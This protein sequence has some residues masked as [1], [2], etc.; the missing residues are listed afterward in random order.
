MMRSL[1]AISLSLML[2]LTGLGM[3]MARGQSGQAHGNEIVI[4]TG[5][6]LTV[7]SIGD[8]GKPVKTNQVCPDA[9]MHLLAV[10]DLP[11][12]PAPQRQHFARL[13]PPASVVFLTREGLTPSARGPPV[14]L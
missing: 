6:G 5:V 11:W 14:A 2:A 9:M 7:I 13:A 1:I 8:D 10:I 4:C 12:Y 3:T